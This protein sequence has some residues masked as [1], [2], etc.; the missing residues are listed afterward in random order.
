M[1]DHQKLHPGTDSCKPMVADKESTQAQY[2]EPPCECSDTHDEDL[3]L[4]LQY[5]SVATLN[6]TLPN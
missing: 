1:P 5:M 6:D 4:E 2:E 3:D